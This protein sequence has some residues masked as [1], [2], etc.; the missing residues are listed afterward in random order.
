MPSPLTAAEVSA[1]AR[2]VC[3]TFGLDEL[4]PQ[5]G[6]GARFN[7]SKVVEALISRHDPP[8]SPIHIQ[9]MGDGFRALK[10][11]FLNI[12]ARVLVDSELENSFTALATM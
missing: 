8:P 2:H 9:I 7:A 12:G 6:N 10:L 11:P 3:S 4:M 1:H 5:E